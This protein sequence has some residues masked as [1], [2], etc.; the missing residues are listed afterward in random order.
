MI[1][2]VDQ[3]RERFG[4]EPICQVLAIAPSSYYA[5]RARP[6]SAR[7][8][9]EAAL[10]PLVERVY[11][12]HYAVYGA[13]KV[14]RQLL[15]EGTRVG[16]DQVARL[17]RQLGLAGVVR[18]ASV[19]T[20]RPGA[21]DRQPADLVGRAFDAPA[22]DRLWVADI[23]YVRL[24][25]GFC[26]VAFIV[27]AFSRRIVGWRVAATLRTSLALDALELALWAR[28]GN[29]LAGL[30]HHSD[31]GVQYLAVR[32]TE[33]LA[34][35]GALGSVGST[36]DSYDNALAETVIGLYKTELINRHG[37]WQTCEQVELATARWVGWWNTERLHSACGDVPPA[38]F[39]AAYWASLRASAGAA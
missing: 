24:R 18:R 29:G 11:D 16:R 38:E 2:F 28:A 23:T 14:W 32:Y 26:Y 8:E 13:R 9:R 3:F 7:A 34:A 12:E 27:D 37:P 21:P 22:P 39:E 35:V 6:P 4:V 17:M 1:H 30:V 25:R 15:R 5:A 20:T 36:G 19:R 10:A 33:R 31:R